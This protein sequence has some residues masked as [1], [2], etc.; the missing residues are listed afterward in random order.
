MVCNKL[1]AL[2]SMHLYVLLQYSL[3]LF[4]SNVKFDQYNLDFG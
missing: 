3:L 2:A 1:I 4:S